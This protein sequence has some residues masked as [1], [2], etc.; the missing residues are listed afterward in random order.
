M[1]HQGFSL[2]QMT[3]L[4]ILANEQLIQHAI[5]YMKYLQSQISS[6][7]LSK[8]ILMDEMPVYFEDSWT[9]TVNIR[10]HRHVVVQS[11]GFASMRITALMSIWTDGRKLHQPL[12]I[13]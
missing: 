12:F 6:I 3:N 10:G 7:N 4:T 1:S 11:T 5:D 8:T 2:R 13:R 9:Q